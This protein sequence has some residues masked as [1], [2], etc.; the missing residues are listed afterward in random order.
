MQKETNSER[1][2][3]SRMKARYGI[4]PEDY[5]QM[6]VD[7]NGRCAICSRHAS[8]FSRR[9]HTDHDHRTGA[10]RGLLCHNCNQ[11]LGHAHDD[12]ETLQ[13]AIQYLVATI[14]F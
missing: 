8:E 13:A 1:V 10:V 3:R 2:R 12:P 14:D 5:D 11:I 6:Y 7:Q 4:T 9:L